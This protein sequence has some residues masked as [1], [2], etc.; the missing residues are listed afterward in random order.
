MDHASIS[1]SV[2]VPEGWARGGLLDYRST[3]HWDED[4][5][6]LHLRI[7]GKPLSA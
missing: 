5:L 1:P 3:F 7:L 6:A 2:A 4:G